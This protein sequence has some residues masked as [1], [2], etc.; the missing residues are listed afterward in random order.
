M[1][2]IDEVTAAVVRSG[3]VAVLRAA[4]ADGFAAVT[5]VLV[6][7]GITAIE[8]TLTSRGA[9]QACLSSE[10]TS[11]EAI[12]LGLLLYLLNLGVSLL[13]APAFAVGGRVPTPREPLVTAG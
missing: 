12:A 1:S 4:T 6:S 13:G 7:A 11:E 10:L 9:M 8:V 2:D 3:V 5:D